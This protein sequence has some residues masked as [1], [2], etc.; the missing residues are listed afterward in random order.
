MS[1]FLILKKLTCKISANTNIPCIVSFNN[2]HQL[3]KHYSWN[4]FVFFC[5]FFFLVLVFL[6]L[7]SVL[8]YV[9][10]AIWCS[11]V[12][13]TVIRA[14]VVGEKEVVS[15]NDIYG[16][17]IKRIQ[18]EVKQIKVRILNLHLMPHTVFVKRKLNS[19]TVTSWLC[20]CS[21]CSRGPTRTSRLSSLP[22]CPL[23]VALPWMPL[24]RRSTWSQVCITRFDIL[25]LC[26]IK[27]V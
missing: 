5:N 3:I 27:A 19:F 15:G 9:T 10:N 20:F 22:L 25:F 6:H 8:F 24:A 2:C 21:R 1:T 7:R 17:P 16:N 12:L 11:C 18:Y 4:I 26:V 14:K 13:P 23:F